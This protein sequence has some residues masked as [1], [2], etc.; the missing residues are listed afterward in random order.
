MGDKC[1]PTPPEKSSTHSQGSKR[2]CGTFLPKEK[3]TPSKAYQGS[4]FFSFEGKVL[5]GMRKTMEQNLKMN[6]SDN[7]ALSEDENE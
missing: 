7:V 1:K 4:K 2:R 6:T 3:Q 5:D